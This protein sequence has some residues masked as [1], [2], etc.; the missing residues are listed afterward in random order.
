MELPGF[1]EKIFNAMT[2]PADDKIEMPSEEVSEYRNMITNAERHHK[3]KFVEA[4]AKRYLGYL[5][6]S[7][8]GKEF[9]P[10]GDTEYDPEKMYRIFCNEF[11]VSSETLK[12]NLYF[13][14]P[15]I[16]IESLIEKV[17]IDQ[18]KID[19]T[20]G[21]TMTGPDGKPIIEQ[22]PIKPNPELLENVINTL[23]KSDSINW[24]QIAK[25]CTATMIPL[26]FAVCKWGWNTELAGESMNLQLLADEAT[27]E[28][29]N[30]LNLLPDPEATRI[31]LKDAKY[32]IFRFY[33]P[34]KELKASRLY[35]GVKDLKGTSKL[36]YEGSKEDTKF[37]EDYQGELLDLERSILYE[38]WDIKKRKVV[39]FVDGL[40]YPI[41][42]DDWLWGL[43]SYPCKILAAGES[44]TGFYPT[45]DFRAYE[46]L[47]MTKTLLVQKLTNLL[48][49]LNRSFLADKTAIKDADS[50]QKLEDVDQSGIVWVDNPQG[51]DLSSF[52][53]NLNDFAFSESYNEF[54]RI[55]DEL[56]QRQSGLAD[57]QRGLITQAKRTASEIVG[58][59]TAQN[60]RIEF[61]KDAIVDWT[62]DNMH[63]FIELLQN[64]ADTERI[65]KISGDAGSQ[66]I[67]WD[68]SSIQG[69]YAVSVDIGDMAQQNVEVKKKEAKERY[70]LLSQNPLVD[71]VE[72]TKDVLKAEGVKDPV[73][74]L[75]KAAVAQY[76]ATANAV[77][78]PVAPGAPAPTPAPPGGLPA[79][80]TPTEAVTQAV[81]PP[82]TAA[83]IAQEAGTYA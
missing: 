59:Q 65:Q 77:A 12:P 46:S 81:K 78:P 43:K 2:G 36:K 71:Q 66:F 8:N 24:K 60:L 9:S 10:P 76:E 68:K 28:W 61:K 39:A 58:L 13:Q 63:L 55:I 17:M 18:P 14:N 26:N 47:V 52:V 21:L 75:N 44:L 30:P 57:F 54:I 48:I 22:V 7:L 56:L 40:D 38:I 79:A 53:K 62:I 41:R 80:V 82:M 70:S 69:K 29:F 19:P 1:V 5:E 11:F 31:D 83:R 25:K 51:K 49:T 45:P 64:N 33:K 32:I 37:I 15:H 4:Y 50:R 16:S 67:P 73:K 35:R 42:Y 74:K 72:N 20:T 3:K 6:G 23:L 34:T 27:C